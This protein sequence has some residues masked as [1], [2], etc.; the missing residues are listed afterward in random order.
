MEY[1]FFPVLCRQAISS[2]FY[3]CRFSS[4]WS[5][6][7]LGNCHLSLRTV[8]QVRD[9]SPGPTKKCDSFDPQP[10]QSS[11]CA[12][13]H[14]C[15]EKLLKCE[16]CAHFTAKVKSQKP[17]IVKSQKFFNRWQV[18]ACG[19]RGHREV[20][21]RGPFPGGGIQIMFQG[22]F[23]GFIFLRIVGNFDADFADFFYR[24]A[25][26]G[27]WGGVGPA[28]TPPSRGIKIVCFDVELDLSLHCKDRFFD[29]C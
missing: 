10:T 4:L 27:G 19:D 17:K 23:R 13:S 21:R 14:P 8:Q 6:A 25:T 18:K 12:G 15:D 5:R 9:K 20:S 29:L 2:T 28:R 16:I 1:F 7:P 11:E 22:L 26:G 3:Y 24:F